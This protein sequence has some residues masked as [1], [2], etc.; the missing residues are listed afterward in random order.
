MGECHPPARDSGPLSV[1]IRKWLM[2]TS[3]AGGRARAKA[4]ASQAIGEASTPLDPWC[5]AYLT[6]RN[7][8]L[9]HRKEI[10]L[11]RI[12]T[13]TMNPAL[14]VSTST[15]RVRPTDK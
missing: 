6:Y 12:V 15:A 8:R 3:Q 9:M 7:A 10:G 2:T 14:D 11:P 1:P 4:R 5:Q 13:L